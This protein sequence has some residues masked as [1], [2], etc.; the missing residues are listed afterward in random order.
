MGTE[1]PNSKIVSQEM[2]NPTEEEKAFFKEL[3]NFKKTSVRQIMKT[4]IDMKAFNIDLDFHEILKD[5][6]KSGF[7]RIP[8]YKDSVD[9]IEGVLYVKDLFPYIHEEKDFEWQNLL[10]PAYFIPESK[11]IDELLKEF[12]ERHLHMAIVVDEY[13]GV[14]GL[15]T[16]EDILEEI[17]GEIEDEFDEEKK[18]YLK[19]EENTFIFEGKISLNDFSKIVGANHSIFDK[20]KGETESLG[21][22]LLALKHDMPETGDKIT[23]EN[24]TFTV[25]AA[26]NKTI[27][28]IKVYINSNN[29]I[30]EDHLD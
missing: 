3:L 10:R 14:A 8:V 27:S 28:K 6:S 12:Q 26:N 21:G 24:F 13:G 23:F 7:S 22:L 11:K 9:D 17:V 2:Q 4:R 5:I 15:V 1:S 25:E 19:L 20:V 29:E 18:Q 16:L 30:E